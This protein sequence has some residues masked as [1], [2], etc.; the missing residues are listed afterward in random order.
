MTE[1]VIEIF[2]INKGKVIMNVQLNTDLQQ[3]VKK[4]LK[5]ITGIYVKF[6][7]IPDTGFMIRIPLEP[8]IMMKY[9]S[10]NAL[11][12]EVIIIF[13]GQ[14]NPYLMVFDNENRPY[15]YR[16]EGDTDKFLALLNFKP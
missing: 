13:S 15:F 10:F 1:K 14:E 8:N 2:D 3:E 9:Q 7:P 12:D 5:G 16:F 11:V 6:K 4:F